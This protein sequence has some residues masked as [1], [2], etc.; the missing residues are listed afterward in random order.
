MN[1]SFKGEKNVYLLSA[2]KIEN[3]SF[4]VKAVG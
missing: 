2:K 1:E 3:V 4:V